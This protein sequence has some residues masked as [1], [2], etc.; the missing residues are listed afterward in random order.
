MLEA[1]LLYTACFFGVL[2]PQPWGSLACFF[3]LSV[4]CSAAL[5]G[6]LALRKVIPLVLFIVYVGGVLV[7][8]LY[9]IRL[10]GNR[11]SP[12][13]GTPFMW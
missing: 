5:A 1:V 6:G 11:I 10:S 4:M 7:V 8:L 13:V 2:N 9:L 12:K 3:V